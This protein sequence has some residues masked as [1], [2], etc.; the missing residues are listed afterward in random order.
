MAKKKKKRVNN[1]LE[2]IQEQEKMENEEKLDFE[3]SESESE[4]EMVD[5]E[6]IKEV[7]EKLN[8]EE[9]CIRKNLKRYYIDSLVMTYGKNTIKT[10]DG[11][12]KQILK[13]KL[14]KEQLI[15]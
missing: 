5:E 14:V 1:N 7:E 6:E 8:V 2:N 10:F 9:F 4:K 15:K 12:K 3:E 11:W 13:D